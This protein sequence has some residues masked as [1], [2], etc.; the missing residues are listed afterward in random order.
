MSSKAQE[1]RPLEWLG[2]YD[3]FP[4]FSAEAVRDGCYPRI[5]E[6][7]GTVDKSVVLVH[8]LSD[9]PHFMA[10]IGE[11]F[12]NELGYNV[13][14]PL[15]HC[16]GLRRPNGMEDVA[17]EEWKANVAFA[18]DEAAASSR[19]VSI[20]GLSTGGTL[21]FHAAMTN[22][23]ITGS[24]YLF[25]A[26]LDLA[27]AVLGQIKERL[28]RFPGMADFL[29]LFEGN[30]DLI[31]KNPYRYARIDKDGVR[32]LARLMKETDAL[33]RGLSGANPLTRKVFAAHSEC[34]DTASIRGIE[35]IRRLTAPCLFTFFR[36]REVEQVPHASVVLN[37]PVRAA[38][39]RVLEK[40]NP[41]FPQM[42][43][44]IARAARS[45]TNGSS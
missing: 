45:P 6:H 24:L 8:G 37:A 16:H 35:T 42:M 17:L 29:E 39:G 26:A 27:G 1:D 28:A 13:Y 33:T 2:Y 7:A 41:R 15:L 40:A 12:F 22:P 9:S 31:G 23:A 30:G 20:G 5:L 38:D 36:L 21:S 14:L 43:A 25:S 44:A 4:Y 34:D 3:R 11:F 18:V 10:A 19:E 32:E